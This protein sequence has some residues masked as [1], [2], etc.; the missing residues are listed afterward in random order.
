MLS[1]GVSASVG[2]IVATFRSTT[3]VA[4]R[5]CF[6]VSAYVCVTVSLCVEVAAGSVYV[7]CHH[8]ISM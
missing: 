3:C 7:S 4:R 2:V 5:Y 1:L 8:A 6:Y